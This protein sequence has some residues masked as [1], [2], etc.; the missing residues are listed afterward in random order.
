MIGGSTTGSPRDIDK[1]LQLIV[2]KKI[3]PW[4]QTRSLEDENQAVLDLEVGKARIAMCL[5]MKSS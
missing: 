1:I 2:D 3:K 5:S 4:I